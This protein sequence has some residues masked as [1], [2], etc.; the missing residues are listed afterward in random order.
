MNWTLAF[1][2]IQEQPFPLPHYDEINN[3][4]MSHVGLP[5]SVPPFTL[6]L[7]QSL[8]WSAYHCNHDRGC[9]TIFELSAPYSDKLYSNYAITIQLFH[10]A[11]DSGAKN[12]FCLWKPNITILISNGQASH[13]QCT[14]TYST[15]DIWLISAT[16]YMSP[17]LQQRMINI[18]VTDKKSL[19][20]EHAHHYDL[21]LH[22]LERLI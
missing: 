10:L 5:Q 2:T 7:L 19:L 17:L 13:C 21:I 16:C 1:R 11:M 4:K 22:T 6:H 15:N 12:M 18:K 14:S 3:L 9:P 8:I 20:F